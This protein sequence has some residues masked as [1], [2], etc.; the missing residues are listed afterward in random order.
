MKH[1]IITL[2]NFKDLSLLRDYL[3]ITR[4]VLVPALNSQTVKDFEWLVITNDS[5]IEMIREEISYPFVPMF[6]AASCRSYLIE[7]GVNIQ[8]RHDCDD[9]M[10]PEYVS[11]IHE[12]YWKGLQKYDAFLVQ[13]QPKKLIY[14]TGQEYNLPNYHSRRCS[15]HLSICQKKVK[16]HVFE[17]KH[18][19]MYEITPNV[20]TLPEGLTKWVIHEN[21]KTVRR[22][23]NN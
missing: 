19:Q 10:S 11:N 20:I 22:K 5:N 16:H 1:S 21:N 2:M 4:E 12:T 8:T 3:K 14:R 6:G 23:I 13:S 18:G 17:R 9:W 15:M 7:K